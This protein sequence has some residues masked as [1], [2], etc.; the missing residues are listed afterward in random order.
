MKS[1]HILLP[2]LLG[3]LH[4]E[5]VQLENIRFLDQGIQAQNTATETELP[6]SDPTGSDIIRFMNGDLIHGKFQGLDG[7]IK[8]N[9]SDLDGAIKFKLKNLRQVVFKGGRVGNP[10]LLNAHI[11]LINGDQIPGKIISMDAEHL[12][13]K[14][15][16][17]GELK[18][19]RNQIKSISPN[20]FDGQ[21]KYAGPF[22]SDGWVILDREVSEEVRKR[23]VE[24]A[25]KAEE[26]EQAE[27]SWLYSGASLYSTNSH[28]IAYNA[29]LPDVGRL[30]FKASWKNRLY[31]SIAFHADFTRPLPRKEIE[32]EAQPAENADPENELLEEETKEKEFAPL[33][34]ESLFDQVVDQAF[35]SK[36]W[37]PQ[38]GGNAGAAV[39]GS[40]YVLTISGSYPSLSRNFFDEDGRPQ[41]TTLRAGRINSN[42]SNEGSAEFDLRFDRT[43]NS[44]YLYVDD[45]YACQ[46][47]D[48][49]GYVGKGGSI[50]FASVNNNSR[51][52][53]SDI[54]VT[55][56]S[57]TPDSAKSM[58][59]DDR[60][61]AMLTNG[62][63]RF[64][65]Q[66]SQITNGTAT[67]HGEFS[68]MAIPLDLLSELHF[69]TKTL[70]DPE[71]IQWGDQ[72]GILLFNPVGRI[73]LTP[74]TATTTQLIG[75]S[76]ILGDLR[77][78]LTSAVL[79]NLSDTPDSLSDWVTDF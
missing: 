58:Q 1:A 34:F 24:N 28:P 41:T 73:T 26:D 71:E 49:D 59:H 60:D 53:I 74:Q 72:V 48:L 4:A 16:L 75:H 68:E 67:F 8:W 44:I 22:T 33:E 79:L 3:S 12:I 19:P 15:P 21:L 70:A 62:T 38:S 37:L 45:Q 77:V 76:P 6:D 31:L 30:R 29:K 20:P 27:L 47:N 50:G 57:G 39:F 55:S 32:G 46:W 64:S 23:E 56:W 61:I 69:S 43:K 5:Q 9:R 10:E 11:S 17:A 2:F 35:Q 7:G 40:S 42:L 25:Q 36:K 65:G 52:K 51:I 78:D 54:Y 14:S 66:V 13:L 63:D 18:I